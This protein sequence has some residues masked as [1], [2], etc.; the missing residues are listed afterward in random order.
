MAAQQST[1][2]ENWRPIQGYEGIY[3][4]SDQGRV[5][6]VKRVITLRNGGTRTVGGRYLKH[7]VGDA[8]HEYVNLRKD[9]QG[10]WEYV[11]RL[12]LTAFVGP[13]PEGMEA[14]HWDDDPGNNALENLRWASR[15]DN[16]H[17]RTRNGI[18]NNGTK[19]ATH[20]HR[21]HPF[22]IEN[23]YHQPASRSRGPARVCRK[24]K[25]L[26]ATSLNSKRSSA[27]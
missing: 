24:C 20:C 2:I 23:T 25:A 7:G 18:H 4:V 17:D 12:V 9:G 8:G 21:G 14:C 6:S 11:H 15:T 22:D 5:W 3:E 13:C 1:L 16:M 26:R 10:E 19:W 27:A